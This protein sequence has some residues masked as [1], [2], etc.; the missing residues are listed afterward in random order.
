MLKQDIFVNKQI[1]ELI[2]ML[3]AKPEFN[4]LIINSSFIREEKVLKDNERTYTYN[5]VRKSND[6]DVLP[7]NRVDANDAFLIVS[8]FPYLRR[9]TR[10][11]GTR[12]IGLPQ[13][14]ANPGIFTETGQGG[15]T[16]DRA[17][18]DALLYHGY[19]GFRL[20][21][22][23]KLFRIPTSRF[24]HAPQFSIGDAISASQ[25]A[26]GPE[27]ENKLLHQSYNHSD[28]LSPFEPFHLIFGDEQNEWQHTIPS[29]SPAN[30]EDGGS[31]HDNILGWYF[32]GIVIRGGA[33]SGANIRQALAA[34]QSGF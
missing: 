2:N 12:A 14:Y 19:A 16:Y 17:Q 18:L 4:G 9:A 5:L 3:K 11:A 13:S 20:G 31:T 7:E 29:F 33:S 27:A 34:Q 24:Y 30:Y 8:G 28:K 32:E 10:A 15:E 6:S 26:D 1:R 23:E 22:N 25:D 21:G